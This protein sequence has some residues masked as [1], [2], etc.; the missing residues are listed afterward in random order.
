M[1]KT[2]PIFF[3]LS[4]LCLFNCSKNSSE[5]E[6]TPSLALSPVDA[7][8]LVGDTAKVKLFAYYIDQPVFGISLQIEYDS[9]KVEFV[10]A[11]NDGEGFF[12]ES[13]LIFAQRTDSVVH[14]TISQFQGQPSGSGSG[15]LAELSFK[16][17]S[18]GNCNIDILE[19]ELCFYDSTGANMD[20]PDLE[21]GNAVLA[22]AN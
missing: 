22:V 20:F 3:I 1:K 14:L 7:T 8:V 5:P 18:A 16:G 10:Q 15:L 11:Q 13:P 9:S 6:E 17:L 21:I 4:L 12:T 19:E 2:I